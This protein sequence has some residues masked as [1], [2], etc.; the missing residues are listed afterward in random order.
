MPSIT[1]LEELR[2]HTQL[3]EAFQRIDDA[4]ARGAVRKLGIDQLI[5]EL[6]RPGSPHSTTDVIERLA[7]AR[8]NVTQRSRL[9]RR[10]QGIVEQYRVVRTKEGH[11][12]S[13]VLRRLMPKLTKGDAVELIRP[14]LNDRLKSRR[15]TA[16]SVFRWARIDKATAH[17][18]LAQ[19]RDS[20]D[21]RLLK[22]VVAATHSAKV[23][24][25]IPL[26]P[27]FGDRY[28][29]MRIIQALLTANVP[30]PHNVAVEYPTEFLQA[31]ARL[32]HHTSIATARRLLARRELRNDPTF[33]AWFAWAMLKMGADR[34][35]AAIRRLY[36]RLQH[37]HSEV[38]GNQAALQTTVDRGGACQSFTQERR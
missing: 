3:T 18:L 32:E 9:R 20:G 38:L 34:E 37:Q 13:A 24:D 15:D 7:A 10:L 2:R 30:V 22:I 8:L 11:I 23:V 5:D 14:L 26:L 1:S 31:M 21:E 35:L 17:D 25:L 6:V 27:E 16:Y 28:W 36:K 19:Y 29:R 12:H 33:V 4:L